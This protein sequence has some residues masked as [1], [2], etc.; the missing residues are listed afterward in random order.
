MPPLRFNINVLRLSC[1]QISGRW[2]G[3]LQQSG[4]RHNHSHNHNHNHHYPNYSHNHNHNPSTSLLWAS[5]RLQQQQ[6]ASYHCSP[7]SY[8]SS[9]STAPKIPSRP[10]PSSPA[11]SSSSS[12]SSPPGSGN[13]FEV[14]DRH[15]KR[16]H[17]IRAALNVNHEDGPDY[18]E[19]IRKEAG[20]RLIDRLDDISRTFPD[21]LELGSHRLLTTTRMHACIHTKSAIYIYIYIYNSMILLQ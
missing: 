14:F 1:E 7:P 5:R 13:N 15:L 11:S 3:F 6:R 21:A 18:F 17:R 2:R 10:I 8:S 19:Y 20:D 12:S 16:K 4:R 9:S